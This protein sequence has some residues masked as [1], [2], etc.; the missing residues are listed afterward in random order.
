MAMSKLTSLEEGIAIALDALR[1]NKVRSSLTIL[2]VAIGVGVVVAMAAAIT[3]L[4]SSIVEGFESA[5]PD[6]FIVTRFDFS[7][8]RIVSDGSRPPWAGKPRIEPEEAKLLAR[9]PGVEESLYNFGMAV[10]MSYE[11]RRESG[12]QANGYSAGWVKYTAGDFTA[13]RDFTDERCASHG[14]WS[15]SRSRWPTSCSATATPSAAASG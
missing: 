5:G 6:N 2:G 12:I 10:L 3:G 7:N 14:R 8:V 1:A 9:L 4:R 13:G 11:G 15:C